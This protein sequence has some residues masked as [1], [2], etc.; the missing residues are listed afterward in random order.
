MPP[1]QTDNLKTGIT[2]CGCASPTICICNFD[3][4]KV[5]RLFEAYDMR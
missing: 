2:T 4:K 5:K 1:P 3:I